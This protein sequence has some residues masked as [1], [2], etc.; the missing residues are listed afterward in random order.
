MYGLPGNLK[1]H[2]VRHIRHAA[3]GTSYSSI[4]RSDNPSDPAYVHRVECGTD[5]R[6]MVTH[7]IGSG[8]NNGVQFTCWGDTVHRDLSKR[9]RKQN[10]NISVSINETGTILQSTVFYWSENP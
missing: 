6:G 3:W 10:G 9:P 4:L 7:F 5:S 1:L 2:W 8:A